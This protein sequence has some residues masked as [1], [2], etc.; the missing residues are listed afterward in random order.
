MTDP[1]VELYIGGVWTDVTS[2]TQSVGSQLK[3]TRGRQD[4]QRAA[5]A[6][7]CVFALNNRDGRF[8]PRNPV[9]PFYGQIGRN[10]QCRVSV[11]TRGYRFWGEISEWPPV[12]DQSGQDAWTVVTASGIRR[13][14]GQGAAPLLGPIT[15]YV[16]SAAVVTSLGAYWPM[17]DPNG[18]S[19]LASGMP[20]G[21]AMT[22]EGTSLPR[23]AANTDFGSAGSIPVLN[24]GSFRGIPNAYTGTVTYFTF[25]LSVPAGGDTN[26]SVLARL[27]C[28]TSSA[29]RWEVR[30][31]STGS[32]V[33]R[34]FDTTGASLLTSPSGANL[35]GTPVLVR[36]GFNQSGGNV[37]WVL[38]TFNYATGAAID[39]MSG[40][41][42]GTYGVP[43]QVQ[44]NADRALVNTA[45]G[46]AAL[47]NQDWYP[48]L[49]SA[50]RGYAG[51]TAGRR[52]QRL[53]TEEG[54]ALTTVGDL[55][56]TEAMGI[57][58]AGNLL[59]LLDDCEASDMGHLYE[60]RDAFGL[61]YR[62]RASQYGVAPVLPLTYAQLTGIQPTEDD[63][64]T[65]NDVTVSRVGGSSARTVITTGP[66]SVQAPP[67]GVGRYQDAVTLSLATDAQLQYQADWRA[68]LGTI[69]E[70]R[71]PVLSVDVAGLPAT[72]A[73]NAATADIGD[74]IT[75]SGTPVWVPPTGIQSRIYGYTETFQPTASGPWL[76]EYN[77]QPATPYDDAFTLNSST[78]G[79]L[80]SD[81]S[82]TAGTLTTTGTT[83]TYSGGDWITT[84]TYPAEFPFDILITGEQMTVTAGTSTGAGTGTLT[85]TRSVNGVI[86]THAAGEAIRL[87][88]PNRLVL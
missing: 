3:I 79:R 74:L 88:D 7:Q 84:A 41:F 44:F 22:L 26:D 35:N 47:F 86:K 78:F 83:V 32:L 20:N 37:A 54:I 52:I 40:S 81:S 30:Y 61:A 66:L 14:L 15:R 31:F 2:Y 85:V 67:N 42:A 49:I 57:Q 68:G 43:N 58:T 62:T 12:W 77:C 53:T 11:P 34:C 27:L 38:T 6:S 87:A 5:E 46:Q 76:I 10:T 60:P 24:S 63:A 48:T 17:T 59:D 82:V 33:L 13:R 71:Y 29:F 65:R 45:V 72:P 28:N 70:P 56:A 25:L 80:D 55:D 69:D 16:N 73:G 39:G 19:T 1:K 75:V 51:E 9:G 36:V 21:Q 50:Y 4:E 8:S 23:L 64:L 18:S